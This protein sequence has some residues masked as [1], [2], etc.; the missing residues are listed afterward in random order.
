MA[1]LHVET[2]KHN[3]GIPSWMWIVIGIVIAAA[4]IYF[5]TRNNKTA[6]N[7]T[8][9]TNSFYSKPTR[10]VPVASVYYKTV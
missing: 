5:L 2:K 9:R 3:A 10:V 8:N 4:V 1:E 7:P 6:E